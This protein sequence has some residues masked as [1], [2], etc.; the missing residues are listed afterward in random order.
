VFCA[1]ERPLK[2]LKMEV[3]LPLRRSSRIRKQSSAILPVHNAKKK[4]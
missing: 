1:E 4:N 3:G 2:K